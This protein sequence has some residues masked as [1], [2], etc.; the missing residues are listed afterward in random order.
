MWLVWLKNRWHGAGAAAVAVLTIIVVALIALSR[1]GTGVSFLGDA[2]AAR[3][4]TAG[5]PSGAVL[6]RSG[7]PLVSSLDTALPPSAD[8]RTV[9][10]AQSV[11]SAQELAQRQDAVLAAVNCVR[12]QRGQGTLMLDSALSATAGDAWLTLVHDPSW[13][14]MRLPGTYALRGVVSLDFASPE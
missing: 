5:G 10:E 4:T 3:P 13:L 11:W 8:P 14:L 7:V 12:Q 1:S 2:S 6:P 9:A